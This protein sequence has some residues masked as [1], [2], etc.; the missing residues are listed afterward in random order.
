MERG[1]YE[2]V[3]ESDVMVPMRD[4]IRLACDIY[5]PAQGGK[6]LLGRHPAILE[7]TPYSKLR[8]DLPPTARH[9]ASHGYVSIIQDCRGRFSSEGEHGSVRPEA[10]DGYDTIEWAAAQPWCDGR[11]GT[12]GLS[13]GGMNQGAAG[14]LDP[15]HLKSMV[16]AMGFSYVASIRQRF[17]GAARL[18]FLIRQFRMAVD[19]HETKDNPALKAYFEQAK[20]NL[21]QWLKSLPLKRGH[22]PF[23]LAPSYEEAAFEMMQKSEFHPD[24]QHVSFD[25]TPYWDRYS[26]AHVCLIGGWYDSHSLATVTAYS[27]LIRREGPVT[28]LLM[29]PW[30]HGGKNLQVS[31]AG[32]VDFGREAVLDYDGFRTDWFDSTLGGDPKPGDAPIKMFVMGGGTGRK[33]AEG[34]LDHG[35]HWRYEHEWPLSRAKPTPFYLQE[36]GGLSTCAPRESAPTVYQ[37][38]PRNPVPTIGG[39]VSAAEDIIPGGGFD[40]VARPGVFGATDDLPLASRHDVCVFQSAPLERDIEAVGPLEV[41][42]HASSDCVDTDFTAKLI[43]VYPPNPDYPAGYALNIQ[44]SIIR[45]RYRNRREPPEFLEPGKVY[46]LRM[47]MFPTANIFKKGHRIRL[48]ISSSNFPRFDVNPNTGEPLMANGFVK[49]ATNSV[50]HDRAHPSHILLPVI[51]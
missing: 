33:T 42:L 20:A 18:S 21:G 15:P 3:I 37:F 30:K 34:R 14:A 17:G 45:A 36:G 24:Y 29:G 49:V 38:D 44:D 9:F 48:D 27:H 4:G 28:R 11:V 25:V 41:V 23:S 5:F 19:A 7:R 40:Q 51:E 16:P 10:E 32:D 8:E 39:P 50:F 6:N 43:D 47:K 35:G 26:N 31:C 22:N 2:A 1:P 12:V 46:E 13:Y